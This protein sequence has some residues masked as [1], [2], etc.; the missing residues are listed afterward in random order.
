LDAL[1][2]KSKKKK[3]R[4]WKRK[5]SVEKRQNMERVNGKTGPTGSWVYART[6]KA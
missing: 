5:L 2:T 1:G 6:I 3:A 4:C